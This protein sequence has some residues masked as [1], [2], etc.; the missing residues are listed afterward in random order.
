[1]SA[2]EHKEAAPKR[3][4]NVW[5]V[6]VSSTRTA[7]DDASGDLAASLLGD[8]GHTVLD[9]TVVADDVEQIRT[10]IR[11][12]A[13][14][15]ATE[16]ALL[17]GGTGLSRKDVTPE[18]LSALFTREV[19][20]FGELFRT[21]SYQRIG[22]S[23]MLSRATAGMVDGLL[24]FALPGSPDAVRLG[25]EQLILPELAHLLRELTKEGPAPSTPGATVAAAQTKP[26]AKAEKAEAKPEAKAGKAEVAPAKL[27]EP[28]GSLGRL[29]RNTFTVGTSQDATP[30]AAGDSGPASDLPTGWLRAVYELRGEVTKG[31]WPEVPEE[32]EKV[33][34]VIDVL[35]T[36]GARGTLK[37]PSGRTYALFGWPNLEA[38]AKVL[39]IASG[40]PI[41][42]VLA[43]HRYPVITGTSIDESFGLAPKRSEDVGNVAEAVTGRA[44]KDTS[45]Q[46]F[47]VQGDAVIIQRGGKAVRWDGTKERE[48]GFIKQSLATLVLDWSRR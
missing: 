28:S 11:G 3:P 17:T 25:L 7:G 15:G 31:T 21:L 22:A 48:D 24:V 30:A 13:S 20:G 45:G 35:H 37:L 46:L 39:A 43:L 47:A 44:P 27:P 5:V 26:A 10:L 14:D 9:R 38:G 42:E 12:L 36:S 23:A 33:A 4:V 32:L 6:T 1:M 2:H 29:G 19:P 8:A 40:S 41:G 16:V 18:A 34:P